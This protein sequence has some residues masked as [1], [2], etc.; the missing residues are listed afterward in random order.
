M[1]KDSKKFDYA[2][3]TAELEA[4]VVKVEDP[5][6]GIDDIGECVARADDLL[7]KC[8]AYLRQARETLDRLDKGEGDVRMQVTGNGNVL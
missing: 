7:K 6:T 1:D 3:A 8:R 5:A 2:A 4:L